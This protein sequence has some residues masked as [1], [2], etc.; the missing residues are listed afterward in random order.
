MGWGAIST[1]HFLSPPCPPSEAS[2]DRTLP[3][4]LMQQKKKK[5]TAGKMLVLSRAFHLFLPR[6]KATTFKDKCKCHLSM[7]KVWIGTDMHKR[8]APRSGSAPACPLLLLLPP[9][10]F[11]FHELHL[12]WGW[13]TNSDAFFY[14]FF[15]RK[16]YLEIANASRK[17]W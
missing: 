11:S 3:I 4:C 13:R 10:L 14:L 5:K 16:H 12:V 17:R 7:L 9:A 1:L 15:F 2:S 8:W 6:K